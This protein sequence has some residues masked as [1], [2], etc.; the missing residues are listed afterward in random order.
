MENMENINNPE[1]DPDE[2]SVAQTEAEKAA[3]DGG[4]FTYTHKCRKP[5]NYMGVIYTELRFDWDS[6]TGRDSLA[7]EA[8]L[9]ALGMPAVVPA[10]SGAYL[11]RMAAKACTEKIGADAFE[12][13]PLADYNRVRSAARS[14]L[15]L[16][17]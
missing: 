8:E 11:I 1:I 7:I 9:Q 10:F 4:D 5:F 12:L 16:S 15:L 3:L 2:F 14:F 17:E 6:L 13:M